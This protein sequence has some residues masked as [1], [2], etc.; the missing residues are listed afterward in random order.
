LQIGR[1]D[2]LFGS[3]LRLGSANISS[4]QVRT[5][6]SHKT[7]VCRLKKAS[8]SKDGGSDLAFLFGS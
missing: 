4:S 3:T 7:K 1:D 5:Y 2:W 8:H 6:C